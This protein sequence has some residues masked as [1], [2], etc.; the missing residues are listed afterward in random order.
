MAV[1]YKDQGNEHFKNGNYQEAAQ[2]YT[3]AQG[4]GAHTLNLNQNVLNRL[5]V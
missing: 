1:E 2:C 3:M 4:N 5:T